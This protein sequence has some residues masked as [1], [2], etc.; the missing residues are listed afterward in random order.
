VRERRGLPPQVTQDDYALAMKRA[1]RAYI[2]PAFRKAYTAGWIAAKTGIP[3]E[4]CPYSPSK[5]KTW[6]NAFRKAWLRGWQSARSATR[7]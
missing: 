4:A 5:D 3:V 6:R 7:L 2:S 1:A